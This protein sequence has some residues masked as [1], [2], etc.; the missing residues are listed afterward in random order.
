MHQ[1]AYANHYQT[2]SDV[3]L[4]LILDWPKGNSVSA[5]GQSDNCTHMRRGGGGRSTALARQEADVVLAK[6][7]R[8]LAHNDQNQRTFIFY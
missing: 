3:A 1:D 8:E 5:T 6:T 4:R 7:T 2:P